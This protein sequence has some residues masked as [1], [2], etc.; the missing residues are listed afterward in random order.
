[1]SPRL[2]RCAICGWY[3]VGEAGSASWMGQFRGLCHNIAGQEIFLTGVGYYSD[4]HFG[5]FIAPPDPSARWD[6]PGYDNPLEHEFGVMTET[7]EINGKRGFV[8]HD[9]CWSLLQDACYPD[10]VPCARFF[11]VL[12]SV[13]TVFARNI[14]DWG[15]DYG[16]LA[17]LF[18]EDDYF[19]WEYLR[20]ADRDFRDSGLD[21]VYNTN[22]LA[23]SEIQEILADT[24]QSP[25][26]WDHPSES[27]ATAR[28]SSGQDP[29]GLLPKELCSAIAAYLPT[30]DV[31]NARLASRSFWFTFHSQQFW[32]SR[33][34]GEN[35]ERSWLF[36]AARDLNTT[37][38][39]GRRDWRWL[40]HR[41]S[42]TRL[43]RAAQ[44]RKRVWALIRHVMDLLELSWNELTPDTESA[45]RSAPLRPLPDEECS[46]PPWVSV[47]GSIRGVS[48]NL[49][50][51]QTACVLSK[52]Q[53]VA[54][55][56]DA[57]S[58][59]AASTVRLGGSVYIAG[60]SLTA[61]NGEV[62]RL[63]YTAA[64]TQSCCV[65]LCGASLT[66]FNVAVGLGG[67][68]ALQFVSGRGTARRLSA[69]L[70]HPD[71]A[72]RTERLRDI[73]TP[74]EEMMALEFGFDAF[75]MVSVGAVR[76]VESSMSSSHGADDNSLRHSAVWYPDVPSPTLNLNEDFLLAPRTYV[77]GFKPLFWSRF[78]GPG[79]VHL[80]HLVKLT[81]VDLD[82][83]R[84]DFS[85]NSSS[86]PAECWRFSR[87]GDPKRKKDEDE[88][89]DEEDD[90]S[91]I[92]EFPID[93]PGGEM[94][95]KVEVGQQLLRGNVE[96]WLYKEG[97]L[98]WL[99]I[100]TNRERALE[101]GSKYTSRRNIMVE[102]EFRAAP[103]TAI[104]GFY[105]SR[106]RNQG[107]TLM[108]LGVMTEPLSK[109]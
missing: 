68:H 101:V 15:H 95:N 104:T 71:N 63:G 56:V 12:N 4:P 48:G 40:Y 30:R 17:L 100:H 41:T 69:W 98:T 53:R 70:G 83:G 37:G 11:D 45:G 43:G 31:L 62:V 9:A 16:G 91:E 23:S 13:P 99:K 59:V 51:L 60:L 86:V 85:F 36:E 77:S 78:G 109:A 7:A 24:P 57:I 73:V 38:G 82:I 5:G 32:A 10:L 28:S 2:V 67:I 26:T 54:I 89:E 81:V 20:F 14:I 55:R 72:P 35:A 29:F 25:P 102:K 50:G 108:S 75:R 107:C 46:G 3:I 88:D 90:D 87:I 93:G 106:C 47:E 1:M 66:G 64:G 33:F 27:S 39:I 8:I 6:D 96:N 61:T 84:I 44:N 80:K 76:P 42:G 18:P 79:G 21:A 49:S 103:G 94:I 19:P 74:G 58:Q 22:P 34:R 52:T 65:H 97:H 105:G 92:V